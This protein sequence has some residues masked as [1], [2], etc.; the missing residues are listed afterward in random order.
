MKYTLVIACL[1]GLIDAHK[2]QMSVENLEQESKPFRKQFKFAEVSAKDNMD[3]H[4]IEE[5]DMLQESEDDAE[6]EDLE[7]MNSQPVKK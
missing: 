1:L 7:R 4:A 5:D 2:I 3:Q 6:E